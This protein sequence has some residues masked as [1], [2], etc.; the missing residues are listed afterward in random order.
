MKLLMAFWFAIFFAS[1]SSDG[2][3]STNGGAQSDSSPKD[4][5][6][7]PSVLTIV[8]ASRHAQDF[9]GMQ[10]TMMEDSITISKGELV[11]KGTYSISHDTLNVDIDHMLSPLVYIVDSSKK[12]MR[13][14]GSDLILYFE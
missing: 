11:Q 4:T 8:D 13:Q 12:V 10:F 6:E 3:S 9:R 2:A 5:S 7:R 1:C 14:I